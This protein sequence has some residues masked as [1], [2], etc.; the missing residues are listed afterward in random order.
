MPS[1]L[2]LASVSPIGCNAT[3]NNSSC[4]YAKRIVVWTIMLVARHPS[5][6][7]GCCWIER[8][9]F[10]DC[11]AKLGHCR[12][13]RTEWMKCPPA[14]KSTVASQ[15]EPFRH[16]G[17]VVRF[18]RPEWTSSAPHRPCINHVRSMIPS[19]ADA[20]SP[21]CTASHVDIQK[22]R[23]MSCVGPDRPGS[24]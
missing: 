7:A 8:G 15:D 13:D 1:F 4:R 16:G 2:P 23:D 20:P 9:R 19:S 11:R 5:A 14:R 6:P 22:W 12:M 24:R 21:Y 3:H 18:V 10:P 17:T